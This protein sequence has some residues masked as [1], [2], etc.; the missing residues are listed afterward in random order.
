MF[1]QAFKNIDDILHKDA[2][3]TSELDYTEQSSWLLFL[4]YLDALE[5]DKAMEAELEGK[6]YLY[7]LDPE[8]RWERWAAPKNEKGEIDHNCTLTGDDLKDFVNNKLF[9]YLHGFKQKASGPD[10]IQYKIGEIFGEIKNRIQSGY[11]LREVLEIVDGLRFRSQTE[12]HELSH[13]YEVKIKNMGNAG[14]NGG[15]YYTP[16]PLIRA[17]IQVIRPQIGQRIYDGAVGSAG[18]LCEAFD[19][20]ND[21]KRELTTTQRETLQKR[22]FYGKEK[23]SLAYV[24][25]IM[26]MILHGIEAPNILH[27]NTLAENLSDIQDKDRYDVVL[28]NPPFG[29][30]ERKEVQQNFPIKTGETAYLFLQHFIKIIRA[31]GQGAVVIKN[32]FLSNSDNASVS[33]RKLLLESCNLHTVLDCPGGTFLG[34]GVKTVVLFFQKGV[35]T[36]KIWYYQLDPGRSMGKTNSLNDDDLLEFIELQKTSAGSP[37]SWILDVDSIDRATYDLSVK[38]PDEG[39][40]VVHRSPQVIMDEIAVLD[41]ESAAVL[42]CI[43]GLL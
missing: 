31:G 1:E 33:L 15:E 9:P 16:R 27:T 32:T 14:R 34:A 39:D 6:Y 13:L 21:Q 11:N 43:R 40:E 36:R 29:G 10:T 5:Q 22:T 19:Y 18:F 38:N 20:L 7:I 41:A 17:M 37:K 12:K 23:K 24:I 4:K 25:A 35:P 30:K 2:G 28:A 3:C 8:Y 26:N 42:A